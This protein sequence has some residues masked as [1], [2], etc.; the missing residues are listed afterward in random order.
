MADSKVGF[1][2]LPGQSQRDKQRTA[3]W[4]PGKGTFKLLK[5]SGGLEMA[6]TPKKRTTA[7]KTKTAT[8]A[9]PRKTAVKKS[10]TNGA[11]G[12]VAING[13]LTAQPKPVP[14]DEVAKLAHS[15]WQERGGNHGYHIEDW[16]RAEQEL[17][18]KA[19]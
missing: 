16:F 8:A 19:S 1:L 6:D 7:T 17:R 15:Y 2:T 4:A 9:K 11:T 5:S 12:P 3:D 13:H 18:H 14:Y 10:T